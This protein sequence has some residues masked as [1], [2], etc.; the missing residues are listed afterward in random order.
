MATSTPGPAAPVGRDLLGRAAA[1]GSLVLAVFAVI[2]GV[3]TYGL[4]VLLARVLGPEEYGWFG[5]FWSAILTIGF[6]LLLPVEQETARRIARDP[7]N[8]PAALRR[9]LTLAGRICA[10]VATLGV[11]TVM[12]LPGSAR[13][14]PLAGV[15]FVSTCLSYAGQFAGRGALAGTGRLRAYATVVL[16]DALARLLACLGLALGAVRSYA[17]YAV[18]VAA[19][20]L[21]ATVLALTAAHRA[22]HR[23]AASAESAGAPGAGAPTR[24]PAPSEPALASAV[25][26][27]AVGALGMQLLLNGGTVVA[28]TMAA[29]TEALVA[30]HLLATMTALRIPVFLLQ[31]MQA[32]YVARVAQQAHAGR[33][34]SLRRT[35][36]VLGGLVLTA[37][38][39]TVLTAWL[40]GPEAVRL[41]FGPSYDLSRAVTVVVA[42]GVAAYL[43]GS[44]GN[45]LAVALGRHTAVAGAWV[46]GVAAAAA[47][48]ALSPDLVARATVPMIVGSTVAAL[49]LTAR[50]VSAVRPVLREARR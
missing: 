5:V 9:A 30:G 28:R 25:A 11:L 40:A 39:G 48:Y 10:A 18:A 22:T 7:A 36:S 32:S 46:A 24:R 37:A 43:L 26:R 17:P 23:V 2:N 27:L 21:V 12:L 31:S 20:A 14:D 33:S 44:V 16:V 8:A 42:G 15:A 3:A 13:L 34:A 4:L 47:A 41:V 49:V 29:P 1:S 38:V 6:G 35:L 19:S 45:D 50:V